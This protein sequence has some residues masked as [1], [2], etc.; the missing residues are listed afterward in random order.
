MVG[1]TPGLVG[2]IIS[3]GQGS[4]QGQGHYR[5]EKRPCWDI[6]DER[7][8]QKRRDEVLGDPRE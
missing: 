1:H 3:N 8:K 5:E 4:S 7:R 2:V 6:P